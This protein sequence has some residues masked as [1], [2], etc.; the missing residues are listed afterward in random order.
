MNGGESG[1]KAGLS[2][3]SAPL[4]GPIRARREWG[5]MWVGSHRCGETRDPRDADTWGPV[6][7]PPA[8]IHLICD[9][10]G[11]FC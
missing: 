10:D 2:S 6:H 8:C 3:G 1:L 9:E 4:H 7:R 11:S 5:A